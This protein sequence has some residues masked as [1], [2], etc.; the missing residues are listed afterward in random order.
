MSVDLKLHFHLNRELIVLLYYCAYADI[1][2]MYFSF[3]FKALTLVLSVKHCH[4]VGKNGFN[5]TL[6]RVYSQQS[7]LVRFVW[8]V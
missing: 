2:E 1:T 8:E 5:V 6:L 3:Y 7:H 4:P